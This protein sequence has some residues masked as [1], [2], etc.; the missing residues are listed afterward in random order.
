[1]RI[2]EVFQYGKNDMLFNFIAYFLLSC[3][4]VMFQSHILCLEWAPRNSGFVA[5]GKLLHGLYNNAF[6]SLSLILFLVNKL[7]V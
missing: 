6:Y 5:D 7:L 3:M 4:L 1:M 2:Y